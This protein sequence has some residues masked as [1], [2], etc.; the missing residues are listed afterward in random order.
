MLIGQT[1]CGIALYPTGT[2][3]GLGFR[4]GKESRLALDGRISKMNLSGK[5][6]HASFISETSVIYRV[7]KAEK[8][9][10]HLGLGFRGNWNFGTSQQHE[11]GT[12]LPVGI[13]A[14]P[15]PF[16]HAGLFFEAAPFYTSN[17]HTWTAGIR[18]VAGFVFY[19]PK[20]Q[21]QT[22]P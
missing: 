4:S 12:V 21:Q 20:K 2:E 19:F 7:F 18:T 8:I 9:R 5:P 3:T 10:L 16:Q 15:F 13:E 22:N 11:F 6:N 17:N 1:S 14:F